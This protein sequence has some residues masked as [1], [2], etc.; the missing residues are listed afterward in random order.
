MVWDLLEDNYNKYY[1]EYEGSRASVIPKNIHF[2]WLGGPFPQ[3]YLR[4]KETW[5][6]H[7]PGWNIQVWN[8]DDAEE[9][10]I[11]NNKGISYVV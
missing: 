9:F 5:I 3:K 2:I 4:L 10:G 1:L 6:K 11:V 8:D 7:H